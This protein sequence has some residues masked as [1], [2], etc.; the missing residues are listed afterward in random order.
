MGAGTNT[1]TL[2]GNR[3]PVF[4]LMGNSDNGT[5]RNDD[6]LDK[7]IAKNNRDAYVLIAY[8]EVSKD[9]A[10]LAQRTAA[11]ATGDKAPEAAPVTSTTIPILAVIPPVNAATPTP[12]AAKEQIKPAL[13]TASADNAKETESK[14][15]KASSS[16]S[17]KKKKRR[18]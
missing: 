10:A 15:A 3:A 6:D 5:Y 13:S 18:S 2:T 12:E 7:M 17:T 4:W 11:S 9:A 14:G 8:L 1:R 16:S